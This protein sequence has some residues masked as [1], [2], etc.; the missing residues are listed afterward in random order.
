MLGLP[1]HHCGTAGEVEHHDGLAGGEKSLEE[2]AL[3]LGESE[4]GAARRLAAVLRR[5]AESGNDDIGAGGHAESLGE[6]FLLGAGIA[7]VAAE[8]CGVGLELRIGLEVGTLGV[9]NLGL[10][11]HGVPEGV[12]ERFVTLEIGGDAPC[13]GHVGSR[14]GE[15]SYEGDTA[16]LPERKDVVVVLE[17]HKCLGGDAAGFLT[18]CGRVDLFLAAPGVDILVGVVEESELVFGLEDASHCGVYLTEVDLAF[19]ERLRECAVEAVGDHVHV[20]ARLEGEGRNLLKITEAVGDHLGYGRVVGDDKAVPSPHA[21]EHVSEQPAVGCGGDAV[22]GVERGHETAR[23]C[24]GACLVGGEIFVEHALAAHVDGVVVA[25]AFRRAVEGEMLDAGH[26]L[27][28][29]AEIVALVALDHG[30]GDGRTEEWIFARAFGG[31]SPAWVTADV[32]HR[33]EGPADACRRSLARGDTGRFLDRLHV[34]RARQPQRNG[35]HR[36]VAVDNVHAENQRN[37]EAAFLD[38]HALEIA[39]LLDTFDVEDAAYLAVG[40]HLANIAA[41]GLTRDDIV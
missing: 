4:D 34:P 6:E 8:H 9:D 41:F 27:V 12:I 25:S 24:L 30:T 19:L 38:S 10:G 18:V 21:A 20:G 2:P 13:A 32:D 36:L 16:F 26:D 3:D 40:D 15:R 5:L 1:C 28:I 7:H 22:D 39:D 29:V 31:A 37:A 14:V 35:E 33:A 17:E 23:T 11:A